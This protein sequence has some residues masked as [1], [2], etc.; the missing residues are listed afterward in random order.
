MAEHA[1]EEVL[2]RYPRN[3]ID[4]DTIALFEGFLDHRLLINKCAECQR[5]FQP[6]W[7]S[8]PDCWSDQVEPTEV[9]GRGLVHTFVILHKGALLG[10]EG[11]DYV[12]GHPLAVIELE[13]QEGLR[14]TGPIVGCANELIRIGMPVTLTW[15]DRDGAPVPAFQPA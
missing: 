5:Y 14:V 8:C 4:L 6:P 7:P 10:V 15:I 2:G 9:S 1:V 12:K 11:V 13:E 3:W